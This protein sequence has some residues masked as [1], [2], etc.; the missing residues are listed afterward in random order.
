MLT[1]GGWTYSPFG[2]PYIVGNVSFV[3]IPLGLNGKPVGGKFAGRAIARDSVRDTV[4][5]HTHRA[6]VEAYPK[7]GMD[8]RTLAID[9]GCALPQGH[10]ES[11]AGLSSTGWWWGGWELTIHADRID[12]YSQIS[13]RALEDR[14]G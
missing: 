1:N 10:V 13:M 9:L 7:L 5:G 2:M 11:Y 12:H 4:Y 8:E 3:H 6:G 14:Y